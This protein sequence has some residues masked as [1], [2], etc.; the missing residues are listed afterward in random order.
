MQQTLADSTRDPTRLPLLARVSSMDIAVEGLRN[1]RTALQV[2][3]THANNR[4]VLITGPTQGMGKS[5]VSVNLASIIAA[6]GRRVLLIDGDLRDGQLHRYFHAPRGGGLSD[7]LAGA[8]PAGL[9]R[10]SVLEHLDFIA[11][12]SLPPNPSELLLRPALAAML[13]ELEPQYDVVLID[14]APLLAVAD[15]LVIGAHAGTIFLATRSGVTRP[16]EIAESMKR[17][18]RAG[19]SARGVLFNDIIPRPGRYAYGGRYGYGKLRQ[20][21]YTTDAQRT[22]PSET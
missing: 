3:L 1:F 6:S 22:V 4:V 11:T 10:H 15:S 14:A 16:G 13:A 5:F 7:I 20:L 21:G 18:A 2:C 12:G 8:P 17:L 9:V 19:L